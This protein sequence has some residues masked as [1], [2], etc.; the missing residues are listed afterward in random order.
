M[1]RG[2]IV[3]NYTSTQLKTFA[4]LFRKLQLTGGVSNLGMKLKM[5]D[6]GESTPKTPAVQN[7]ITQN[8]DN[9]FEI[10]F[11]SL[12]TRQKT[13]HHTR[14]WPAPSSSLKKLVAVYNVFGPK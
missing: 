8:L 2:Q 11:F 1:H 3:S 9:F 13:L 6:L 12:A 10:D 14:T 4:L 5:M 7:T